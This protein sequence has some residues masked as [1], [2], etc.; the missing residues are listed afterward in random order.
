MIELVKDLD[1]R[2]RD[3]GRPRTLHEP[4][5]ASRFRADL[6][7]FE[8]WTRLHRN[9]PNKDDAK[10]FSR[11]RD[12]SKEL[13]DVLGAVDT[14]N[15]LL[16][17]ASLRD[18][19]ALVRHQAEEL[20]SAEQELKRILREGGWMPKLGPSRTEKIAEKLATIEWPAP[21]EHLK[22][23]LTEIANEIGAFQIR[24]DSELRSVLLKKKYDAEIVENF[25]HEWR[26]Q[27]RWF[28]IYLQTA[29]GLVALK[30]LPAKPSKVE[31]ALIEEM[32]GNPFAKLPMV[33][34]ARVKIDAIAYYELT[35]LIDGVGKIKE[36]A[37]LYFGMKKRLVDSGAA[38]DADADA[39]V[40][41]FYGDVP[42]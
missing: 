25:V 33:A 21:N 19:P 11:F 18:I 38:S 32:S 37:E 24:F 3:V 23:V 6:F 7:K 2:L 39:I 29:R 42:E 31:A 5:Q 41:K 4:R 27:I 26:R 28:A 15:T 14:A 1:S 34:G 17:E 40:R 10:T 8:G 12:Q 13:E 35:R 22:Y 30:G 16:T 9:W 36:S 20:H